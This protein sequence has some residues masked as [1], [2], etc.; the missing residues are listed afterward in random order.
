MQLGSIAFSNGSAIPRRL[1]CDGAT[2]V[3]IY[4]R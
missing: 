3:G 4:Q 1:T 2:L